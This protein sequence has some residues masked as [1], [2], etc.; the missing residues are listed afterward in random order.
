M[1]INITIFNR[2][3]FYE[4]LSLS[5]KNPL[6]NIN[7]KIFESSTEEIKQTIEYKNEQ[8]KVLLFRKKYERIIE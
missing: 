1:V 7:E 5:E 2:Y 4:I 8:A 6:K 3:N